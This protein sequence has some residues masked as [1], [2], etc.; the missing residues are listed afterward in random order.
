MKKNLCIL[1]ST[2]LIFSSVGCSGVLASTSNAENIEIVQQV[3]GSEDMVSIRDVLEEL[4]YNINWEKTNKTLYASKK[5]RV[6]AIRTN[7]DIA[8]L[9][10]ENIKMN[11]PATIVNG[12]LSVTVASI[13]TLTGENV[14]SD[15]EIITTNEEIDD[16]WKDNNVSV[17]LNE[18]RDS[19]YTITKG[20]IYILTG[21][22]KG[23]VCV[24]SSDKVK[25]I[26][27]GVSITNDNGPAIYFKNS[28]KG[29]IE[30]TKDSTNK[31]TDGSDY[32]VDAKGCVF[33]N[34]DLDIQGEGTITI[35]ANYNHGIAS[36]DDIKI[37]GGTINITTIEGDAI[38][39]N[40]GVNVKSGSINI[41]AMGDGINGEKYV[42]VNYGTVNIT[43]KGEIPEKTNN[44]AP[45][46]RDFGG[47]RPKIPQSENG[48]QPPETP[49]GE[50]KKQYFQ[51]QNNKEKKSEDTT[52][53][54]TEDE[55]SESSKGI[56]SNNLIT[57]NGGSIDISSTDHSIKCDNLIIINDGSINLKSD[58]SK[59]IKAGGC[60]FVNGG[61]IDIDSKDEGIE[62][63]ST[64]TING[65]NINIK[66]Q[67][68]GINA[69]GGSGATMMNNVKDGDEHQIIVNG[70]K[71]VVNAQGDGLDSNGNLCFFGGEIIV[72]GPTSG[73]NGSLDSASENIIYGGTL[74][75]IGSAGM[76][77]C[78][79]AGSSQNIFN[80]ILD[81][82]QKANS[83]ILI[84]DSNNK[85]I[86]ES[87]SDKEFQN[88]IFSSPDIKTGNTYTVYVNGEK[89]VTLSAEEGV[90]KYGNNNGFR[91]MD[92]RM[93]N[94]PNT[95]EV[96]IETE[97]N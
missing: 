92:D 7:S 59:G 20:G 33:S 91:S 8:V 24:D 71:L 77:E 23:M 11:K 54:T 35:N 85:T 39:A 1:L 95:T 83:S 42:E 93:G 5:K 46:M 56:K 78:P 62:S 73:G 15:E 41:E 17:N 61:D 4:G 70:G 38:N 64:V 29:I 53:T 28:K 50:N 63:K 21:T 67:D 43:T 90:S 12:S 37:D 25:I 84:M 10:G 87:V 72:N 79:K 47:E 19:T 16:A 66:S 60:L 69:G 30:S 51:M 18:V 49:Q 52:E 26:L 82:T 57:I 76:I 27:N 6:I 74:F 75:A 97:N 9:N 96:T 89:A 14:S 65:G 44:D 32:S 45:P 13:M 80:I 3:T 94:R 68:D 34:D 2:I 36:D 58:I 22:F 40:D 55:N 31:L 81:E 48:Q 88:I 86:Y